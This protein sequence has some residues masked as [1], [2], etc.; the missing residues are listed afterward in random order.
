MLEEPVVPRI[1][2]LLSDPA[3][4]IILWSLIDGTRRPAGELA[5]AAHISAQSASGH[6]AKLVDGGL[7]AAEAQGP[8]RYYRIATPE[9]ADAI[10]R[11]A[12]LS[13][14]VRRPAER[15]AR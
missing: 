4:L 12:T 7:L 6:L 5:Y 1:A 9:V 8:H 11:F 10:E 14:A 3:R 13:T 15:D 2:T